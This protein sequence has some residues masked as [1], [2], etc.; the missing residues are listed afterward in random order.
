MARPKKKQPVSD[1][2]GN[3]RGSIFKYKGTRYR[4]QFRD[5][6]G[7]T[8]ASGITDTKQEAED[9]LAKEKVDTLRKLKGSSEQ[10]TLEEYAQTWLA[11]REIRESTRTSYR[12]EIG[13]ILPLLGRKRL[14]DLEPTDIKRALLKLTETK[15]RDR[16]TKTGKIIK[17]KLLASRTVSHVRARLKSLLQEAVHDRIIYVSPATAVRP[18]RQVRTEHPHS[19]LDFDQVAR[20]HEIATTLY[21][22]GHCRLWAAVCT[23]VSMGL[24]NSELMALRWKDID[25][26]KDVMHIRH[27]VTRQGKELVYAEQT[28]TLESRR[29][30]PIPPNLKAVL[31]QHHEKQLEERKT[32]G[33]AWQHTDAVFATKLGTWTHP[34]NF[35]R[36]LREITAWSSWDY[37]KG[38]DERDSKKIARGHRVFKATE[39]QGIEALIRDGQPLPTITPHDLRHTAGTLMLRRGV[40]VEAVSKILGHS[41]ITMTYDVYRHVLEAEIKTE[42]ID[43]LPS[44]IA[45]RPIV[46]TPL[47]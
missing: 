25:L 12:H 20:M 16:K 21:Q 27:T 13:L 36:T 14:K 17:G 43:L 26:E 1:K 19:A 34:E 45:A 6:D 7:N 33:D 44:P 31:K 30:I 39:R 40:K 4:W 10:T 35:K 2:R 29:D 24:R 37:Y 32:A 15:T 28:K 8:L 9:E 18:S 42:M 47:N 41:S 38:H 11:S 22:V 23:A 3:G 46:F 5:A